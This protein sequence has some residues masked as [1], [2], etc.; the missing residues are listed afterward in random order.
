MLQLQKNLKLGESVKDLYEYDNNGVT[1]GYLVRDLNFGQ[2]EQDY[3]KFLE[4]LNKQISKKYGILL[5]PNNRL[6]PDNDEESRKEW[7]C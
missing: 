6:A 4:K 1:T 3:N 5:E 7:L 2:F